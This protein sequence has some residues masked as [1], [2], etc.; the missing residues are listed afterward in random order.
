VHRST[1]ERAAELYG[2]DVR[3]RLLQGLAVSAPA[4]A[5]A[6]AERERLRPLVA[7]LLHDVDCVVGPTVAI[8]APLEAAARDPAVAGRLI[9]YTR[10]ANV[11]GTPA[12]SLP[13][14]GDGLPVGLQIMASD[15]AVLLGLAEGIER[16]VR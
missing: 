11:V 8:V 4:Y 1:F 14:A 10:L 9:R 16:V 6:L 15:D 12:L 13:V 5:A 2:A 3:F 7:S